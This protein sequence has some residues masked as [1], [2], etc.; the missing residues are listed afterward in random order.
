[1]S[2]NNNNRNGTR[3][4]RKIHIL[5]VMGNAIVGGM[6][7]YV[8]HLVDMLPADQFKITCLCPYE[9]AITAAFRQMGHAVY[10]APM[11]DDPPWRS[12][13]T[14]VQIIRNDGIDLLHAHM[15]KAHVLAGLAANITNRPVVATIHEKTLTT[16][17]LGIK[18]VVGSHLIVICQEAYM[19]ARTLGVA[20]KEVSY[21][22]N[23]VN[24]DKFTPNSD[25]ALLRQA[26]GA[27]PEAPLIGFV[28]RLSWEKGPDQFIHAATVVHRH[29]PD[30][31]F[32]LVGE[33]QMTHDLKH[34]I[35]DMHLQD[36]VHLAGLWESPWQVYPAFDILAQTSRTE[37]MPFA[38]L[39]GMACGVPV[40][41]IGVGGVLEIVQVGVTGLIAGPGNWEGIAHAIMYLLDHTEHRQAM[42]KA[43]RQRAEATFDLKNSVRETAVLFER[44][45]NAQAKPAGLAKA[46]RSG[47]H[48]SH[49]LQVANDA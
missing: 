49:I 17:E 31:H 43:A 14:A 33:G 5:E 15:P 25:G 16:H 22:K 23:G 32:V 28:G 1:M 42:A 36:N 4:K 19:Q 47:S 11:E 35:Q 39:E 13:Q 45:H 41:A 21:I 40:V 24:L 44:L 18:Q 27:P 7:N 26:I 29:R 30:A 2:P 6:E 8:R 3:Q 37:G 20:E 46:L 48:E 34:L 12:V 38:L 9:S 10:I